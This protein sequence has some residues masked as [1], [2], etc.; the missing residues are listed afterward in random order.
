MKRTVIALTL[1]SL[2]L[3]ATGFVAAGADEP[4]STPPPAPA[5]KE[6]PMPAAEPALELTA[7]PAVFD[8]MKK[9]VGV[10]DVE[11]TFFLRP[12]AEPIK[13]TCTLTCTLALGGMFREDRMEGGTLKTP[14]G[15]TPFSTISFYT[16]NAATKQID[17]VRMSSTHSTFINVRGG[18][19]AAGALEL[20]GE[21][22]FMNMKATSRDISTRIDADT[23]RVES[24]MSFG[25]SPEFK[26]AEF[27]LKRR[28]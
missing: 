22:T 28:K 4:P 17:A 27:I 11:A 6:K 12:G 15:E 25:G 1:S 20:K 2:A 18:S 26:G 9:D 7:D 24:Y 10:W 8:A 19:N 13:S 21:Y 14:A 5:A 3:V 23:V 16:F